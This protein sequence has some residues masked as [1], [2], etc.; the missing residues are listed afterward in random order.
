MLYSKKYLYHRGVRLCFLQ[1][2]LGTL[3][4]TSKIDV[5][6]NGT[7]I[8]HNTQGVDYI[9]SEYIHLSSEW[10]G[11]T[12]T[13]KDNTNVYQDVTN[14]VVTTNYIQQIP[15]T[16][17]D[18]ILSAVLTWNI[19]AS[20]ATQDLDS[21]TFVY[22]S[23]NNQLG[24]VM[25]SDKGKDK[26]IGNAIL[27]L[28]IDDGISGQDVGLPGGIETTSIKKWD[29]SYT[30]KFYIFNFSTKTK[31]AGVQISNTGAKVTVS[32]L[33]NTPII[34]NSN[35]AVQVPGSTA[36]PTYKEYPLWHVFDY[37]YDTGITVVNQM[38]NRSLSQ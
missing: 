17:N 14:Y 35:N 29:N 20:S 21:W 26:I 18:R 37:N 24:R 34:I 23:N 13:F 15:L 30:L 32:L 27:S 6:Y 3:Y 10:I 9:T 1:S 16:K 36:D 31:K 19:G 25:Y 4:D 8:T 33:N 12:L 38:E 11:S 28:D 7:L 2:E 5:Y 22:D